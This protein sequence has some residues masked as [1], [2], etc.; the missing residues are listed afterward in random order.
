MNKDSLPFLFGA[1]YYRAPTP[2]KTCWEQDLSKMK[3][4]GFTQ[5]KYWVQWRWQHRGPERFYWDDLDQL[6][7]LAGKNGV[8]VTLNTIFDVA[9]IWLYEKYPDAKQID[10][11]GLIVEPFAIQHR[12]IGGH[13]GP[14]Y[15][16]TGALDERK[17]FMQAA[18]EHF[19]DH[20]AMKMWDVWNEPEQSYP[21]RKPDLSVI[22]CYCDACR[23]HF[24]AWLQ[25]KYEKLDR[26][27]DVWGRCYEKWEDVELPRQSACITDFID[28]REFNLDMMTAE[29]KWRLDIVRKSDPKNVA[30][31][32]V[33]PNTMQPFNS[34]TCV[35]DFD[36]A[37]MCDVW[38]ASM[39]QNPVY[40]TQVTS[41]ARGKIS[42]NVESHVNFGS[43]RMHQRVLGLND[44]LGDWLP[45][46][47]LGVKGFLF[48]Q[49]RP[50]VL[51]TESPA[52]GV[53]NLDG[54]DRPVTDAA[55]NFWK[56]LRPHAETLMKC[57]APT[58]EIG[59]YK[60][61]KNELFHFAMDGDLDK[62]S[63]AVNA[64]LF[65][66]YWMNYRARFVSNQMLERGDL[67]GIKLLILPSA[68]YMTQEE[69]KQLDGYVKS[70]GVVLTEAH[71]AS[72]DG[73]IGRY[74]RRTPGLGLADA[75]NIRET[76]STST[77]HLKVDQA[78]AML[79]NLAEDERKALS[80]STAIGGEYV[81]VRLS[82]GKIAWGASRYA[83]LDAP[84]AESLGT[85]DG[86]NPTI[87]SKQIGK[88]AVIY[89]ATNLGQGSKRDAAGLRAIL[90]IAATR[91]GIT[92]TLSA[93]S[94][95][96]V[97][98][99]ALEQDGRVKF[100]LL[101]NRSDKEQGVKLKLPAKLKGLFTG[102]TIDTGSFSLPAKFIDLMVME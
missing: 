92:R 36:I 68:L 47:G 7:D 64:Y 14:C 60:S 62:L 21:R 13:P 74:S 70:G 5:V 85:F 29:A 79:S 56:T 2:E 61:R 23:G 91:A 78:G 32:H 30:Y 83:I 24:I 20:P 89:C 4:L 26:L 50:E 45:Q 42:Y 97:H 44:L 101:W 99:D 15:N 75:W 38:A 88:G 22:T 66:T 10:V 71:L 73:T 6:M 46:I 94:D 34:V 76:M 72:Y 48:W 98:V 84:G 40:T 54:S 90:N 43:L 95:N 57:P 82:K 28:W 17:K 31:L 102:K 59:I 53:V 11:K 93:E 3:E 12:Q 51:G 81:P 41:A 63:D 55:R 8:G 86:Q 49:F 58:C 69:A 35:D 52:W 80:D 27:N 87:I 18:V 16:H 100:V 65:T 96:D 67:A 19:R 33:V 39:N 77:F 37:E 9:P 25:R 1:Q